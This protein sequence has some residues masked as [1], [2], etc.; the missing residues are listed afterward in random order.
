LSKQRLSLSS[1]GYPSAEVKKLP[2]Y[3][4][5]AA[6]AGRKVAGTTSLDALSDTATS[7]ERIQPHVSLS[8]LAPSQGSF[9]MTF[10]D[11][12]WRWPIVDY[13][14]PH[15]DMEA[16]Q[17]S[18][19]PRDRQ[20]MKLKASGCPQTDIAAKVGISPPAVCQRLRRLQQQYEAMT[21]A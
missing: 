13:V 19:R 10:G 9:Y 14:A 17:A 5:R 18:C 6:A 21:A 16:F 4:G 15:M 8:D 2:F 12:R 7:R 20:I 1:S 11:K 3:A